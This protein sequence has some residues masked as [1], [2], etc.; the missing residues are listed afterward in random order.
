MQKR[1]P[2]DHVGAVL[3]DSILQAGLN[4]NSVV[5]VRVERILTDFPETASLEGVMDVIAKGCTEEFLMWTHQTKIIRF[6][7][8]AFFLADRQISTTECLRDWLVVQ[9]SRHHLMTVNG[10]GPKTYDYMCCLVGI[11]CIAVDRHVRTFATEAGVYVDD[12]D[13]LKSVMSYAADLLG[14]GRRDFDHWIWQTISSR[15]TESRQL[16]MI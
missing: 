9:D 15:P 2:F 16:S 11:D 7:A 10:V 12:Y 4:Y 13:G 1:R 5:R 6:Q 3:A 14:I 8:L